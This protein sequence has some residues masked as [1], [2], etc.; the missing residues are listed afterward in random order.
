MYKNVLI[1]AVIEQIKKDIEDGD[2]TAVRVLVEELFESR[3][4]LLEFFLPEEKL[5]QL[6][7]KE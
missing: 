1:D 6:L 4:D 5:G 7:G 3:Q 2:V